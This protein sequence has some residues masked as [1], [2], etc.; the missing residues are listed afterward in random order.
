MNFKLTEDLQNKVVEYYLSR[1]MSI[2]T[3]A[4]EFKLCKPKIVEILKSHN[5]QLY[6]KNQIFNPNFNERYFQTIDSEMKAYLLGFIF[7]DGNV[8][9]KECGDS[10]ITQISL[11]VK[12]EDRY[13]LEILKQELQTNRNISSD[14]R[15]ALTLSVRSNIMGE[16]LAKYNIVPNKSLI[17]RFP[18]DVDSIEKYLNHFLRGVFD[19]DGSIQF[20]TNGKRVKFSIGLSAGNPEVLE[21]VRN[22]LASKLD[23]FPVKVYVYS[24]KH[25]CMITWQSFSDMLKICEYL[26]NNST[27]YLKRK[28]E[29][30]DDFKKYYFTR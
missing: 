13:I 24:N 14:G 26:Y 27:I 25:T 12:D 22:I 2:E 29:I 18:N 28:R 3:V 5:V 7:T 6:T 11:T 23:V 8:F 19:G 21:Q 4:A 17:I 1:P 16:D 20:R 30:Y 10:K 15:G 9:I